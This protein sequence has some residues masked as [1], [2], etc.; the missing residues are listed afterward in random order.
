MESI[1]TKEILSWTKSKLISGSP[2]SVVSNFS[3][4]SRITVSDD[5]F[6]PIKGENYDGHVF[7]V[8]ALKT[9]VKGF[10]YDSNYDDKKNLVSFANRN[11]PSV[12][13]LE[14]GDTVEFLGN[15]AK[16]YLK[17]FKAKSIGI[18]GSAGKTS[19]KNFL[20]NI[21]KKVS[22][23]VFTKKN[24]NNEIGIP[25]TIFD[26][27]KDTMYFIAELGMRA[28]GQIARLSEICNLNYGIITGIG[29]SHLE[30]FKN[31]DEIALAK[32]EIGKTINES[33]GILFLN[34][35]DA[36]ADLVEKNVKCKVLKCG[37]GNGF[38]YNFSNCKNDKFAVYSFD[39][40]YYDKKITRIG[41]NIP[42]YHNVYNA[43]LA[44]S[45][46]LYFGV[47]PEKIKDAIGETTS[48]ALRMEII[49]KEG[50]LILNDCYNANPLSLK[51]AVDSLSIIAK[52]QKRRSVAIIGDMLELG[53]ASKEM[54]EEIGHYLAVKEID[55]L[56]AL[57]EKSAGICG[58]FSQ[59]VKPCKEIHYFKKK[60]HLLL[61]IEKIIKSGD[62]VLIKGSRANKMEN[63]IDYI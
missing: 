25:K 35:D 62:A 59:S 45:T 11:Y 14:S 18:T 43:L 36:Y 33:K 60:E 4:D 3:T 40:N 53:R 57:G 37:K 34:G 29:P 52:N 28:K 5:F 47:E 50:K 19:T 10:V 24:Y 38:K 17:K 61:E 16:G 1:S 23:T 2:D 32:A 12:L 46:A 51:S 44:A 21:L 30:F 26:V 42:G 20:V 58:K 9:G 56:I 15:V 49:E 6:I 48:E 63:I 27:N 55:V 8:D 41:L 13:I 22:N 7:I 54:H 39:L 31:I